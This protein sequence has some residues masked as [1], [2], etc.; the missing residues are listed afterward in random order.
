MKYLFFNL[1]FDEI[2]RF[3]YDDRACFIK[4]IVIQKIKISLILNV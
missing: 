2:N 1:Y 4:K 3:G